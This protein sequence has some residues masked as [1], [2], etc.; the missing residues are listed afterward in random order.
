MA[1]RLERRLK[2]LERPAEIVRAPAEALPF[3]D[4]T[5]DTVVSTLVLCTVK[6]PPLRG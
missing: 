1:K 5:F 6:D 2:R 3:D 4:E